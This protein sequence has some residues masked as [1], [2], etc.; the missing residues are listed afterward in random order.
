[1][2]PTCWRPDLHLEQKLFG[3][4][5]NILKTGSLNLMTKIMGIEKRSQ[6]SKRKNGVSLGIH[7]SGVLTQE[8]SAKYLIPL[9]DYNHI[10]TSP[11]KN[12]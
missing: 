10:D 4:E 1:M 12:F 3:S 9:T 6:N 11:K 8:C 7:R 5:I 2:I